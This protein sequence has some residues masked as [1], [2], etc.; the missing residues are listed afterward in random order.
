M[1]CPK[2]SV[3]LADHRK[4]RKDCLIGVEYI[5]VNKSVTAAFVTD[6]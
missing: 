1:A 4:G 3:Y 5:K 6:K 2:M